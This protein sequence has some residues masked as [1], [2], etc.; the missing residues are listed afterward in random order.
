MRKEIERW[1]LQARADL[2]TALDCYKT[3]NFYACVFFCQQAVEKALKAYYILKRKSLPPKTHD[4][5]ELVGKLKLKKFERIARKLTP[6][7]VITR[8]PDAANAVPFSLYD[9]KDCKE[10]LKDAREVVEWVRKKLK[11]KK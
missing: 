1:F 3:G 4:L 2:K 9:K 5:T 11:A 6:E 7:F 10:S 8:Y